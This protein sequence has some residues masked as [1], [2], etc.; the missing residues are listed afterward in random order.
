MSPAGIRNAKLKN[1]AALVRPSLYFN[2]KARKLKVFTDFLYTDYG[3]SMKRMRREDAAILREK[4]LSLW[5]VGRE[6]ADSI[7]CYALNKPVFVVDAYT[8][9]LFSRLGHVDEK[10]EYEK[11]QDF[12]HSQLDEDTLFFKH[13]HG[14]IVEHC[15][16]VCKKNN[17]GC[18]GCVLSDACRF[19]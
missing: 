13:Y 19:P 9:R 18:S 3:G 11:L 14:L 15:K 6:T 16:Y 1:L 17:P 12:F 4:L 5:G 2:Q 10:V 7:L 8:R